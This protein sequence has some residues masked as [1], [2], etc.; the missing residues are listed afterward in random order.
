M[1][2]TGTAA[3]AEVG[4]AG[5]GTGMGAAVCASEVLADGL[6]AR[7]HG[8]VPPAIRFGGGTTESA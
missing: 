3:A 8:G 7:A 5:T 1:E 2:P 6:E 4:A